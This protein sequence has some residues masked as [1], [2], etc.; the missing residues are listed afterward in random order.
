MEEKERKWYEEEERSIIKDLL[1][2]K[3]I[4]LGQ[5]QKAMIPLVQ[6][7]NRL[8]AK[9]GRVIAMLA[10]ADKIFKTAVSKIFNVVNYQVSYASKDSLIEHQECSKLEN[11][12]KETDFYFGSHYKDAEQELSAKL[13]DTT[14]TDRSLKHLVQ[15]K[16]KKRELFNDRRRFWDPEEKWMRILARNIIEENGFICGQWEPHE[17]TY[18]YRKYA[19]RQKNIEEYKQLFG[20]EYDPL[21][22]VDKTV[23]DLK[24]FPYNWPYVREEDLTVGDESMM[25]KS[26]HRFP[27]VNQN[28][29]LDLD[30]IAN[31]DQD[32]VTLMLREQQQGASS[33][34]RPMS[35]TIDLDERLPQTRAV[36]LSNSQL[37]L[38]KTDIFGQD[39][40]VDL[41]TSEAGRRSA[42]ASSMDEHDDDSSSQVKLS[43]RQVL[44]AKSV[45]ELEPNLGSEIILS[46]SS[47]HLGNRLRNQMEVTVESAR[48][49]PRVQHSDLFGEDKLESE[50]L[51]VKSRQSRME[52]S[53]GASSR[54]VRQAQASTRSGMVSDDLGEQTV[55]SGSDQILLPGDPLYPEN[56]REICEDDCL[57]EGES[58]PSPRSSPSN[59]TDFSEITEVE[60]FVPSDAEEEPYQEYYDEAISTPVG[61]TVA[62]RPS[63]M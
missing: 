48:L 4:D 6:N 27:I 13:N 7:E 14:F 9:E 61:P 59:V 3:R 40:G 51:F 11:C 50:E 42:D 12:L 16:I 62:K 37:S 49:T 21:W 47:D 32:V 34:Q 63:Q 39:Q 17:L 23:T 28:S 30:F 19:N 60:L 41:E 35:V 54:S 56:W 29:G 22:D 25:Y 15:E 10:Q 36:P 2:N 8:K 55:E 57:S 53:V 26:E 18:E 20:E 45:G 24:D 44:V 52:P 5:L 46:E 31:T 58:I 1:K 43:S 33:M 38:F